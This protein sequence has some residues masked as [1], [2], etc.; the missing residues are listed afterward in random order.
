MSVLVILL[1][2]SQ[3]S[4]DY[5]SA[6]MSYSLNSLKGDYIGIMGDTRSLDYSSYATSFRVVS[7]L[8]KDIRS[9][10]F[11]EHN[12]IWHYQVKRY[13]SGNLCKVTAQGS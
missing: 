4:Y 3:P 2:S 6:H 7:L 11:E 9:F 5:P 10:K 8:K 13:S 1:L 12:L